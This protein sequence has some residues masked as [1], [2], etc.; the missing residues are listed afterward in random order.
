MP[1]LATSQRFNAWKFKLP[2]STHT[3]KVANFYMQMWFAI[4]KYLHALVELYVLD[5]WL[6]MMLWFKTKAHVVHWT[7]PHKALSRVLNVYICHCLLFSFYTCKKWHLCTRNVANWSHAATFS[8]ASYQREQ[9]FNRKVSH[10]S[11]QSSHNYFPVY[12]LS[13]N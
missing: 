7:L 8:E 12:V 9:Y 3:L 13:Q 1:D 11:V 5:K 6:C 4:W 10:N 2:N